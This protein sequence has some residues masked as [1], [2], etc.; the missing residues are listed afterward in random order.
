MSST[1]Q[2]VT[3]T[4]DQLRAVKH[5]IREE[6]EHGVPGYGN[7][8]FQLDGVQPPSTEYLTRDSCLQ[9]NIYPVTTTSTVLV[10][11]KILGSDG[12]LNVSQWTYQAFTAAIKNQFIQQLTE[13][14]LLSLAVT[15]TNASTVHRGDTYVQVGIQ[16]GPSAATP[17]Y[18]V[19][20]QGY[21]TT[22][23]GLAWP[24]GSLMDS[25]TGPGL[26]IT[27]APANPAAGSDFT[28]TLQAG[29]R[30]WVHSLT[31]QLVTSATAATRIPYMSVLDAAG[32]VLWQIAPTAGQAAS[33]T[34]QYDIG[35]ALTL[36]ADVN[37]D[38]VMP[39]PEEVYLYGAAQ[40]KSSTSSIQAGDQWQAIRAQVE[41]WWEI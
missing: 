6:R 14:F 27:Y 39:W 33:L 21:V 20:A 12:K 15:I 35:E 25:L 34:Y 29:A 17:F 30:Q 38:K 22:T 41:Q 3:L 32:N 1:P 31:A 10:A 36:S 40:L 13:G 23:V 5:A 8:R 16:M 7:V 2:V 37:A 28:I 24:E 18:R 26:L 11:A 19:L 4:P 9:V